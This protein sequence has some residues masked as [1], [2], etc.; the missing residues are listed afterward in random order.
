MKFGSLEIFVLSDGLFR[1]DGG[2]M[3]GVVP[4][5][6]WEKKMAPDARNRI[7]L[8]LNSLLILDGKQAILVETGIGDKLSPKAAD[9]YGVEHTTTLLDSLRAHG[10]APEDI[11]V[12]IDT[13]LHFDH[14]GWNT[15]R[16]SDGSLEP[17][18]PH[19][20]Y[21]IQRGQLEHARHPT[22]RDLASFL[23]ENFEPM[24]ATGQWVTLSGNR[25]IVPGVAVVL[26]PGH[27]R[28][29]QCV[30]VTSQGR[31]AVF[32]ADLVPTT[33]HLA[34]PWIMGYDLH[35]LDT[36][37]EKK[38]WIPEALRN[39]WLCIFVHDPNVPAAYLRER[40]GQVVAEPVPEL[41][42]LAVQ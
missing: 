12:V 37:A 42:S 34:Y 18:F 16:R 15:R 4:R 8:G 1:L 3:F 35:P 32:F 41:C 29:M 40:E 33:A 11:N 38:R 27:T 5:V 9:I 31:T 26:A 36:L 10:P 20:Q 24:Q 30:R 7:T 14:C 39:E 13:H 2:A 25:E 21:Y 28:D 17:T 6:L 19:A 22:E 23:A